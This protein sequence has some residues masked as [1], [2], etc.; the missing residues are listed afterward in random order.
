MR[1]TD[2]MLKLTGLCLLAGVLVAGLLFPTVGGLGVLSNK[3][4][5]SINSTS[6]DLARKPPP[7][8]T[9]MLDDDGNKIATLY[10][11]YRLPLKADDV[12][13]AMKWAM[14]S[15]EDRRFYEH[16]GVDLRGITRAA[17][18]NST[19][20][21]T[22]GA[23]TLTQQY[24]KNYLINVAYRDD[25]EGQR[26][27]QAP[28]IA[29]KLRE[30]RIA[31][32]LESRLS[33]QEILTGY[34]N[35][36]EFSRGVYGVAAAAKAYF[37]TTPDKLNVTQSALLAGMVNN[38]GMYDPW[39]NPEQALKRRNY[40][41]TKMVQNN[42]LA[43]KD[44]ERLKEKP[45][46][47]MS[48]PE[49]PTPNCLSASSENGFFC[50][51]VV[52]FLEDHDVSADD[53]KTGGYTIK[54]TLNEDATH[55]AK[56]SA[57][58]QVAKDEDNIANTLSLVRPGGKKSHDVV[59][60]AANRDYGGSADEGETMLPLPSGIANTTGIGSSMKIFTAAATLQEGVK[61]IKD[62]VKS[63]SS[64]TSKKFVSSRPDCPTIDQYG[65]HAYCVS[66]A[67]DNYPPKMSLQK[68]LQTSPNT[69]FVRLEEK[70]GM[71]PIVKM[72]KKLGLR[73]TM[74]SNL[75]GTKPD[76]DADKASLKMSQLQFFGPKDDGDPGQ[77]SFTLGV[78]PMSGLEMSNVA[79][80]LMSHGKWCPTSPIDK[81]LDRNGD[82]K[83]ID[84]P[85]CEQVVPKKL[86]DTLVVGLSKD[87]KGE[88][89]A[90]EAAKDVDWDRPMLGKTGTTENNSSGAFVGA[91]PQLAGV[92]MVFRP[93]SPNGGI[94]YG[95]VG[96]VHAVPSD[97]GNMFGGKTPAQTWFGAMDK[98]MDGKKKAKLPSASK[99]YEHAN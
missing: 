65:T 32:N 44:A 67:Y 58:K 31:V 23:S 14:I 10:D 6:A 62:T 11:Q 22:Q 95:G 28:T 7:M 52:N 59:A 43:K 74:S 5:E 78:S 81:L 49:I 70:V 54:T 76:S 80:T 16:N 61:G 1:K 24:V 77:G 68:A 39:Q 89:T 96:D 20:A 55:E 18:S 3:V 25:K 40:V 66:N 17:I 41:L 92:A 46:G 88:G 98:I 45:L 42:K 84:L 83:S 75:M 72:A 12:S 9:K 29:R 8:T 94:H 37:G 63:P 4:G 15:V 35:V 26:E 86:A 47:V 56:K 33:K 38:P 19:D 90:A 30:A 53:I 27:A 57:E 60:L 73:N 93:E 34:L 51:H 64:Y 50:Q 87:P 97:Q 85:S 91:T 21:D 79:A 71:G 82:E 48:E 2:G 36:V 99:K 69:T 13:P